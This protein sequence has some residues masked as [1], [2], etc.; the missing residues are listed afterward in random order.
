MKMFL[1]VLHVFYPLS[2]KRRYTRLTIICSEKWQSNLWYLALRNY[3]TQF[4][5]WAIAERTTMGSIAVTDKTEWRNCLIGMTR[6]P[7]GALFEI[8]NCLYVSSHE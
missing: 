8:V 3:Q 4:K 2:W 7:N 6:N 1:L 5:G